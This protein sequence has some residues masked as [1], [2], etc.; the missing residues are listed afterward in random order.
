MPEQVRCPSCHAAL[1]VPD[2]LLGKNVKCPKCETTFVAETEAP[3]EPE[4]IVREPVPSARRRPTPPEEFDE[5]LPPDE[6]YEEEDNRPRRR[7]LRRRSALAASMVA[8]PAIALMVVG[9]LDI[10]IGV[11][12]LLLKLLHVGLFAAGQAAGAGRGPGVNAGIVA[13]IMGGVFG[14]IMDIVFG[15]IITF[16]AVKMKQLNSYGLA[17]T[18]CILAMLP[19]FNCCCLGLPFG[20]WGLVM[21]NKPEVKDAFS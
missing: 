14:S 20:I 6:E 3:A 2:A 13:E 1:R 15:S 12:N 4:G 18:T 21:L 10:G 16:G 9:G 7:G 17:M 8:G 5:E 11:L 19:C